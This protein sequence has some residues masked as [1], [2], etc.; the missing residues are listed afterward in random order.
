MP[1]GGTSNH[2]F[3]SRCDFT[4][5]I[6]LSFDMELTM[7]EAAEIDVVLELDLPEA[8][9]TDDEDAIPDVSETA[10]SQTRA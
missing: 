3:T 7:F 6:S 2:R 5:L 9:V 1:R 10:I 8:N 4:Q